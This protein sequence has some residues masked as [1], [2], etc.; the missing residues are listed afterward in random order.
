MRDEVLKCMRSPKY[1]PMT[2][3]ELAR[4]LEIPSGDRSKLRAVVMALIQEGL[5]VEGRKSRYEL[6]GKT[7]NQLTGTLRFHP[8]GNAWFFPTL[9]DD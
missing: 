7:G 9:T 6:R 4:F 8:K 5:V 3:S 1:R 2:G